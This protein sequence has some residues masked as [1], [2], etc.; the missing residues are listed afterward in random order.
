MGH[1]NELQDTYGNRGLTVL[2]VTSEGASDTEKWITEKGARYPYAYDKGGQLSRWF[3]V[4]GIPHAALVNPMGEVV[5]KG[6]PSGLTSELVEK[7]LA[8]AIAKPV[9]EWPKEAGKVKAAIGKRQLGKALLLA[10]ELAGDDGAA[11]A[12]SLRAMV[13]GKLQSLTQRRTD[14]DFL[15]AQE[16][17]AA[18][19][20]DLAGLET[21]VAQAEE[22]L[23]AI[24][25]DK[26]AKAVIKA[27][28]EVRELR[29][30]IESVRSEKGALELI[31]QFEELAEKYADN[32]AGKQARDAI[33]ELRAMLG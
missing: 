8:G 23:T 22:A 14:G 9:W 13:D 10:Q 25:A 15:A 26:A 33:D 27:Q 24:K 31:E 19:A 7:H 16:L 6:H 21:E 20:K 32:Y 12:K 18:L 5:W 30:E 1:L 2:G 3:G 17:A 4:S 11:I 28:L 29:V